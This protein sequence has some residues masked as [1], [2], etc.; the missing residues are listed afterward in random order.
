MDKNNE[1]SIGKGKGNGVTV[2]SNL[3]KDACGIIES[4]RNNAARAVNVALTL[5]NWK[6]G[7]RIARIELDGADRATYGKRV[8]ASL[9]TMLT[10][11]YGKGLDNSSLHKYVKF[12]QLFPRIVETRLHNCYL[13]RIIMN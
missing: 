8:V 11:K 2:P 3:L 12:Y 13:G 1:T 10:A 7:E 9:A 6:L 5:R 4:A